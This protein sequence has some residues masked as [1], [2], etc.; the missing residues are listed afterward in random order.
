MDEIDVSEWLE[1]GGSVRRRGRGA[2]EEHHIQAALIEWCRLQEVQW[3]D[4]ALIYAVPNG[5]RTGR[6]EGGR[7]KAEG[8]KRGVPDLTLPCPRGP[9]HGLYL[10]SKTDIGR[11]SPEQQEWIKA[12]KNQGYLA[13][14]FHGLEAGQKIIEDYMNLGPYDPYKESL[15]SYDAPFD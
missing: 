3:P 1:N 8:M 15:Q 13:V 9:Y 7:L 6:K 4:L 2:D 14:V 11:P 12:L 10:E 5:A